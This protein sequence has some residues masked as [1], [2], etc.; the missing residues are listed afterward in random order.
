MFCLNNELNTEINFCT[1][2]I[3]NDQNEFYLS[4]F[5]LLDEDPNE[6]NLI[7]KMFVLRIFIFSLFVALKKRI[8]KIILTTSEF[9]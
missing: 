1:K 6:I 7:W 8:L 3:V 5:L 4:K 9:A 2:K